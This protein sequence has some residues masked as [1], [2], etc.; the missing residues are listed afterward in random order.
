M[1]SCR[2]VELTHQIVGTLEAVR[3][4][5]SALA[6][7]TALHT[8]MRAEAELAELDRSSAR[9][10]FAYKLAAVPPG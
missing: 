8:L 7:N 4:A 3:S 9:S 1:R 10:E 2:R 6:R 5:R